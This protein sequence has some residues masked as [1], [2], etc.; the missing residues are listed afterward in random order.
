MFY[1][2]GQAH[3]HQTI[4]YGE[5]S[6]ATMTLSMSYL[7]K[8]HKQTKLVLTCSSPFSN[9]FLVPVIFQAS[10][11][12]GKFLLQS[13]TS[14]ACKPCTPPSLFYT[15]SHFLSLLFISY[16]AEWCSLNRDLRGNSLSGQIPDE[17]GDCSSLT[18]L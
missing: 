10:I 14:R 4:V 2:I 3:L 18:N 16:M 9:C 8:L 6:P 13:A 1:M 12:M 7:C 17:I 15:F 5:V 11:L